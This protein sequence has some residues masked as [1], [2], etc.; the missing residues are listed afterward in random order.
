MAL[1][2]ANKL[3]REDKSRNSLHG[4]VFGKYT[5]FEIDGKKLFQIDTF[6]SID[7][8]IPEKCSQS[9]QLDEESAKYIVRLL[10]SEFNIK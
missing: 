3:K 10:I 6:G 9:L 4:E 2:K 7:R 8:M 5:T 1:L